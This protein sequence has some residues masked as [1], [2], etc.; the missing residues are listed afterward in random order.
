MWTLFTKLEDLDFADDLALL[1][2]THQHIQGKTDRLHKFGRQV[3]LRINTKKTETM[4]LNVTAPL[5]VKV[6]HTELQP[7]DKFTYLGTI[8]R[9]EGG[10]KEDISSRLG[11]ARNVFKSMDNVWRSAQYTTGT[12]LRLYQSCVT[13]T[14][15]YGSECWR[16]TDTDL[17]KLCSFHTTCL[18]K[19]LRI[20]WPQKIRNEE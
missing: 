10:T 14:L 20:F 6:N 16:M 1:S 5:P 12:K 15:L 19:I 18:R 4:A 13:S 7:T 11:K 17:G 3:G 2:H 9:P 8:I